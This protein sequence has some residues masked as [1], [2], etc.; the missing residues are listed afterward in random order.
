PRA[1]AEL[2]PDWKEK[3]A[4]L[5]VPVTEERFLFLTQTSAIKT[6]NILLPGCFRNHGNYV[7]SLGNFCRWLGAQAEARGIE[8]FPGFAANEVLFDGE[9]VKGVAT[10]DMGID[11]KGEKTD[12]Y[13]PG[14]E[15]HGKYTFFAEGAR[16][17]LGRQLEERFRLRKTPQVYGIGL[18]ELWE[19]APE[20]HQS[21]LVIHTAGWPLASDVY[22]GSFLYHQENRQIAVGF[23]VGLD[24][25][26]PYLSPFEEFQRFKTHPAIRGFLE[27]GKRIS[28]GARA[29]AAGGLQSLPKLVFPGGVLIG[30]EAGFLNASR[31][32]GS[33]CALKSGMLAA[34]AAVPDLKA[35]RASDELSAYPEAFRA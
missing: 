21:G 35:G 18:K 8:I 16:G 14:V 9:R 11:R 4:P 23:V 17:H 31:I 7:I 5:N 15:L 33:H 1:L 12:A 3:G 29:I 27:G 20:R 24:Y 22:G 30:D 19:V 25:E 13:Q 28:Y 2:I 32:K 26:N 10:G 6:P 34:E